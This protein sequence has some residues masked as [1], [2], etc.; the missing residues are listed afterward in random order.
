MT[1]FFFTRN[2]WLA[3]VPKRKIDLFLLITLGV[4]TGKGSERF[5]ALL[6]FFPF[7]TSQVA[8]FFF[9]GVGG[10]GGGGREGRRVEG[11]QG[12]EEEGCHIVDRFS[13]LLSFLVCERGGGKRKEGSR[14]S[15]FSPFL[16]PPPTSCFSHLFSPPLPQELISRSLTEEEEEEDDDEGGGGG[17]C[18]IGSRIEEEGLERAE[19]LLLSGG[20][21]DG[22]ARRLR[23]GVEHLISIGKS[24]WW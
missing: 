4:E 12:R 7:F 13:P 21:G 6:S 22:E 9:F 5:M 14:H 11:E 16:P 20:G 3:S 18:F 24:G 17:S 10:G 15:I 1:L 23:E 19:S 2:H 8:F